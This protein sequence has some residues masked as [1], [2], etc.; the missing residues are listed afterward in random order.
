MKKVDKN[1]KTLVNE[2]KAEK[3]TIEYDNFDLRNFQGIIADTPKIRKT[4]EE[5]IEDYPQFKELHQDVFDS[6]YKYAPEKME[7]SSID[8]EYLLNSKVMDA[9]MASPKYKE[10]RLL[11]RLDIV[12][13]TMGT[14]VIGEKV[15]D[16]VNDLKDQFNEHLSNLA[17]ARASLS[18]DGDS[19]AEASEGLSQITKEEAKKLLEESLENIDDLVKEKEE[20][21]INSIL[22]IAYNKA[23][24][25]SNLIQQWGLEQDPN[26]MKSGYQEKIKLLETIRDSEKLK[27][28]AELS[29]R[30]KEW[31]I[32][33]QKSKTKYGVDALRGIKVGDDI[34]KLLPSESMKLKHPILKRLFK[35]NLLEKSLF[36]YEYRP[37]TKESK[38]PIVCCIDSSG[39]MYGIKEIW[40]KAIALG[41]LEIARMQKR[42][43]Y[44]IHFSASW[45][46]ESLHVN[47]FSKKNPYSISQVINLAEYFEGGGTMFEP[48]LDLAR[49]KITDSPDYNKADIVFIT[50]GESAVRDAWVS[51]FNQWKKDVELK[52]YSVLIDS[53]GNFRSTLEEFSDEIHKLSKFTR[54]AFD[55][56][57]SVIFKSL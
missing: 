37:Q 28:L 39:S 7:E 20:Y 22:D 41:L 9:V 6:L 18:E 16:L 24:E 35:K 15:K 46:S 31:A 23:Q 34:G 57:A 42:S 19:E 25:T 45:S 3:Y 12:S 14:Q 26:Y 53:G 1:I 11:T 52:V 47:D 38:G 40:A 17:Q 8:Y 51:E 56:T 49:K 36:Q 50:D 54:K 5:G 13:A 10:M 30:Y 27:A 48:P 21:R 33:Q 2:V 29:G 43:F 44:A 4:Y 32:A 55:K